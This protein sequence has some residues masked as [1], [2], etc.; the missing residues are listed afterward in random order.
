MPR[1]SKKSTKRTPPVVRKKASRAPAKRLQWAQ[2]QMDAALNAVEAG[3]GINKAARDH[4]VPQTTL[5]DRLSGKAK[6][7]VKPGPK[8]YL[9]R[10]EEDELE[11]YLVNAARL[12]YGKTR[13]QVNALVEKVAKSKGLLRSE[14]ISN[15]WWKNFKRR[16][17]MLSL[18]S[19]DATAHVRMN[20][21]TKETLTRYLDLLE[22]VLN[23]HGLK[24]HP[25]RIYNMDET[26]IPLDP[27]PPK[28]ISARGEK[29][30]RYRC[31]GDKTQITV[32]GCCSA[33]GQAIPPFVIF[34]AKQLN[35]LWTKGEV[36]GTR[37]GLSESG[38][39]DRELFHGW[40]EK[41]FLIHAVGARPL[42]LLV[43][44]HSSHY[45]PGSIKFA[46]QQGIEIFCLPPHT[47]HEAQPLDISFFGPLKKHWSRI[48]H[49]YMQASPGRVIT[50]YNFS[51]L[52]AKAWHAV[53]T[54]AVICAGYKRAGIV[55]F[56]RQELLARFPALE[57][58]EQNNSSSSV[59]PSPGTSSPTLE[60]LK[61]SE[62]PSSLPETTSPGAPS[63][64]VSES[65]PS[66]SARPLSEEK[67]VLFLRR[68]EEGYDLPD[69]EYWEWLRF[70]N[71][72]EHD[73]LRKTAPS[74]SDISSAAI[75]SFASDHDGE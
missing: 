55:P 72:R 37:Y 65:D 45:D 35:H 15:G 33:T 41:H 68:L 53:S 56:N 5:K 28:V 24:D 21:T 38:W 66:S 47:T 26:G 2:E 32:L 67:E 59:V 62:P 34:A 20:A 74:P 3:C 61:Q 29:K 14:C 48:C 22:E 25:E 57:A 42:L 8:A 13:W 64:E 4:G 19:G 18:R 6:N 12:G 44:G 46:K 73:R 54:P 75:D 10:D 23:K 70:I 1:Y 43:D 58:S 30:I 16:H 71:P 40:L 11:E 52:F 63:L 39:T 49:E 50:R 36:P 31:S 69:E 27:K 60:M 17:P 9:D 51:A 7:L